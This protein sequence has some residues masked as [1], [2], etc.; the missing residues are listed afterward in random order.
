MVPSL[1]GGYPKH[2]AQRR[3]QTRN[4]NLL[5][6]PC[7]HQ[8]KIESAGLGCGHNEKYQRWPSRKS[9]QELTHFHVSFSLAIVLWRRGH[10]LFPNS[11]LQKAHDHGP[12]L[13]QRVPFRAS[14]PEP[15]EM[16]PCYLHGS[17]QE[18]KLSREKDFDLIQK[19]LLPQHA[20]LEPLPKT[21]P[22]E[23]G[24]ENV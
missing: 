24:Y 1:I 17:H 23:I 20:H 18:S 9:H 11:P 3:L 16:V 19:A 6:D 7:T 12:L 4:Y 5:T 2:R 10:R 8:T 21:H 13:S 22:N 15:L 14:L